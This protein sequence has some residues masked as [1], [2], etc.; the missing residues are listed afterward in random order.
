MKENNCT[1]FPDRSFTI[2][3]TLCCKAHDVAYEQQ[4]DRKEADWQLAQCVYE[5]TDLVVL[6][7]IAFVIGTLMFFGVRLFGKSFYN[8]ASK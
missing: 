4:V 8:K 6:T 5:S 2:D 1:L 3:W 7:P